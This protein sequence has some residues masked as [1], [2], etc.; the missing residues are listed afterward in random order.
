MTEFSIL[1]KIVEELTV[2]AEEGTNDESKK[3]GTKEI[4]FY[5]SQKILM[6]QKHVMR[7]KSVNSVKI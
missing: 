3:R 4:I 6:C 7:Q 2:E 5:K 1:K